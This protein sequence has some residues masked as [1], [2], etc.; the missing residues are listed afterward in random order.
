MATRQTDSG[1]TNGY[2]GELWAMADA[3]R[4]STVVA[5]LR[6]Q[7][8]E[9]ARLGPAIAGNLEALGYGGES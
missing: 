4:G 1:T 3:L 9:G 7:Q 8:R 2:E 6:Q 5:V